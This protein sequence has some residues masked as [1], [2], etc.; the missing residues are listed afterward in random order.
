MATTPEGKIKRKLDT[1]LKKHK[2]WYYSPQSGPFGRAGVPD[3][4]AIVHGRTIGIEAK[5]DS[6]KKPT[7]LQ[8]KCMEE[9]EKAEGKCFLVYDD[10]TIAEVEE[11]ILNSVPVWS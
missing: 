6:K 3:R 9:I 10:A 5:S 11:Y 1:M 4:M 8:V 2:I 7:P